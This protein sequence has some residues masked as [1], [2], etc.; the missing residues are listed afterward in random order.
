MAPNLAPSEGG[1]RHC[2]AETLASAAVHTWRGTSGWGPQVALPV[3]ERGWRCRQ[4]RR[5][6]VMG[7]TG[8]GYR[9]YQ[10]RQD[11]W[12]QAGDVRPFDS[13]MA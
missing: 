3:T 10:V 9:R 1:G 12:T 2:A 4:R 8:L 7:L 6:I 5:S 11:E 13:L